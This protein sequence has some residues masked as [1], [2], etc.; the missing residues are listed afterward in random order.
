MRQADAHGRRSQSAVRDAALQTQLTIRRERLR[1][2]LPN[3]RSSGPLQEL[4]GQVD[5][6]LER[7]EQGTFGICETCHEE[8]E[9]DR[10][11]ADPLCRNCLDHLSPAEQRA[12]ERDLDLA[13]QVQR[14]L[15]PKP[16]RV[17]GGWTMAYHYQPVG[18]VSGDYCDLIRLEDGTG[19]CLLGDVMG[20]GV[21]ASMLTAHLHAIFRSLSA[22]TQPPNELV[23]KANRVFCEGTV[24]A[25]FA[26]LV[27]GRLSAGG[28]VEICNAGHCYPLH[29]HDG[30]VSR[31][32]AT[33]LPLGLFGDAEYATCQR[34]LS[35]GD[36]LVIHSDGLSEASNGAGEAYGTERL[37]ELL[38]RRPSLPPDQV[39]AELL[40][41]VGRFRGGAPVAD[42]LTVMVIQREN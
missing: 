25:F 12:L 41:D 3:A 7:M 33:D 15:L 27:C 20:K 35:R 42:D 23:A 2:V 37:A 34:R 32:E 29:H 6:A 40:G 8:I 28:N 11:L 1:G 16:G 39:I 36:R 14:G 26:T 19:I 22:T 10:L 4:L 24:S 38:R 5:A 30:T 13:F 21:A 17:A 9:N 31:F 18:P